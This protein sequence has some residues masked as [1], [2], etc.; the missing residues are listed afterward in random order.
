MIFT[1]LFRKK[2]LPKFRG[3]STPRRTQK[4]FNQPGWKPLYTQIL[5]LHCYWKHFFHSLL[6]SDSRKKKKAAF[7]R[8]T[9]SFPF[10]LGHK[11]SS[12]AHTFGAPACFRAHFYWAITSPIKTMA[13][14]GNN[15]DVWQHWFKWCLCLGED[16]VWK[17]MRRIN[18][19]KEMQREEGWRGIAALCN[20]SVVKVCPGVSLFKRSH[21]AAFPG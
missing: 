5:R 17:V 2:I 3:P 20:F 15:A 6:V 12:W 11:V 9:E 14:K 10:R 1:L 8:G 21:P 18:G 16:G 7:F 19:L 13:C 4:K